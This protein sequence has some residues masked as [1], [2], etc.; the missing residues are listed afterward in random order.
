VK[1]SGPL[2]FEISGD[3]AL[4]RLDMSAKRIQSGLNYTL[5]RQA[6]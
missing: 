4:I 5:I 3:T 2:Y 1:E 6:K